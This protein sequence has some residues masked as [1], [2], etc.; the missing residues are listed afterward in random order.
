MKQVHSLQVIFENGSSQ[1]INPSNKFDGDYK[2]LADHIAQG[3]KH[4]FKI[5][6]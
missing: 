1:V 6:K 5:L 4:T 2:L 3:K